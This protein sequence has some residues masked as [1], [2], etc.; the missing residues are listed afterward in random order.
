M[1][2]LNEKQ[3]QEKIK[4]IE[5]KADRYFD[6]YRKHVD[7]LETS[8][9]AKVRPIDSYDIFCLGSML[10]SFDTYKAIC[11][12]D[13]SVN[14]LGK[15]PLIAHD[16]ITVV[17]GTSIIPIIASVQPVEEETGLVYFRN[18]KA[19]QTRG[20]MTAQDVMTGVYTP[21]KTPSGYSNAGV[22]NENIASV[23]AQLVYSG[24]LAKFPIRRESYILTTDIVNV[25]GKDDGKGNILGMGVSGT[26]NYDTGAFS[27]TFAANPT[28]GKTFSQAYQTD[29]ESSADIPAITSFWDNKQVTAKVYALKGSVG[30]LQSY[31]LRKRFGL[32]AEDE[33]A[34]DIIGEINAEIGGDL[35]RKMVAAAVGNTAWD[36]TAPANSS[37]YEHKMTLKDSIADA[38]GVI[39][40]NAG[41]GTITVMLAGVKA[42]A[43]LSTL[44]GF[45][46]LSDGQAVGPHIFGKLDGTVIIRVPETALLASNLIIPIWKGTSP[47]EAP[48][49]YTPYMPLAV[50][51]T[52][53]LANPLVSQKAAA[54]WAGVDVLVNNFITKITLANT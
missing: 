22:E 46:K 9:L 15:I 26:I 3:I 32:V 2:D 41:R 7:L 6:N 25:Y 14:L 42:S 39:V 19:K 24:T 44:P 38:E 10:E 13:G 54:V 17:Y 23:N 31:A 52:L 28:A 43:I 49:V 36:K 27:I 18:V 21:K 47:F 34:R 50:T 11:E 5:M 30:M 53:P 12:D 8:L 45:E 1:S 35:I 29:Y 16:V 4:K 40:A 51:S 48:A 33:L 37:Y 20:N